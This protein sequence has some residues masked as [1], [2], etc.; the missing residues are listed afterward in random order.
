MSSILTNTGSMVALQT[1]KSINKD[2]NSVQDQVS[3]GKRIANSRD[4]AAIWAISTVMSSDVAGFSAISESLSLGSSTV[5]LARSASEQVTEL[6]EEMKARIVAAQEDNVDRAKIQTDVNELRDQI[7]SIVDSAQFNGLNF[8]KGGGSIDILA[9]LN[10]AS[11]GSVTTTSITIA[12]NDLQA[13]QQVYGA[14]GALGV[15]TASAASIADTATETLTLTAGAI[16]EGDSFR[17]TLDGVNYDYVARD[18]DTLNTVATNLQTTL[19]AAGLTGVTF[20][21][22]TV[23]DPTTTNVTL[24]I[25]NNSGAAITFAAADNS[26]GTAGGG[27]AALATI[28]VSDA[29]S[30][31]AALVDI[32]VLVQVAIDASAAF[33][34]GQK[35]VE[36]QN[37]FVSKLMDSLTTGIGALIDAD[38]EEASARLQALQVQQQLGIQALS[39]ANQS[40]QNILALFQ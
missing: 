9:S 17:V 35:R 39:I 34:S 2:L 28:D 36:I 30:A 7:T 6:L 31:E 23:A 37:D 19:E 27:L 1:L 38:M 22:N 3:T 32:E 14:A 21:A 5:A 10:R 24:D 26:G 15:S 18:G 16:V 33:G 4:N 29:V 12:K 20:A 8:L 11:D 40:P 13:V 25:T